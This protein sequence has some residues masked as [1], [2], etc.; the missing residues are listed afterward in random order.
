MKPQPHIHEIEIHYKRPVFD[1]QKS[2]SCHEDSYRI[3]REL[4]N[5]NTIDYKEE[6]WLLLLSNANQVL[7]VAK[8]ST[9]TSRATIVSIS[10]IMQLALKVHSHALIL[11]HNHPSGK[12]KA[13]EADIAITRKVAD[14]AELLDLKLLDHLIIT[15]ESYLSFVQEGLL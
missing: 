3:L 7:H 4:I 5:P 1:T 6:F 10:E 11:A 15:S 14:T 9:G 12:L 8:I 13:S 2:V